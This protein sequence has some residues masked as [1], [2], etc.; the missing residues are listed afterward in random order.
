VHEDD[1]A[2]ALSDNVIAGA[3][4]D[5]FLKEPPPA[6]HPLLAFDNFIAT[7]HIAGMTDEAL[8]EMA[9]SAARQWI[10]LFAGE[11]PQ[12]LVNPDVWPQY[13][14]RFEAKLGFRPRAIVSE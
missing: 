14:D 13:S 1:L 4:L 2:A 11:V 12:H 6:D 3:A 5:V 8:H 10:A 9:A 7:P